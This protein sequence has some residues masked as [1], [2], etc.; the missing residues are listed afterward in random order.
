[1]SLVDYFLKIEGVEGEATDKA[2]KDEID[3]LSWDWGEENRGMT[4]VGKGHGAGKVSMKDLRFSMLT[5]KATPKLMLAC[6]RGDH[7]KKATLTC[8]KAGGGQVDYFIVTLEGVY[9]S[10]YD[11]GG[12]EGGEVLP[13]DTVTLK[14][15]AI[16]FEYRPQA[17]D[18]K[19]GSPHKSG[20]NL[21]ANEAV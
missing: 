16:Q 2:H 20:W 21:E 19:K 14:F 17:A 3:V 15:S 6:A 5:N 18:G 10:K 13:R 9:V 7:F 12:G 1:M 8:R 11:T 4:E